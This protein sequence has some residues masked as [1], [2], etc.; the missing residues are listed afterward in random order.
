[1]RH[2]DGSRAVLEYCAALFMLGA[3]GALSAQE[4]AAHRGALQ[5]MFG[6]AGQL[7]VGTLLHRFSESLPP[8]RAREGGRLLHALRVCFPDQIQQWYFGALSALRF[9]DEIKQLMLADLVAG[10]TEAK[11]ANVLRQ[12]ASV[13]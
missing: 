11:L 13:K 8:S 3:D 6:A 12:I 5:Q 4:C 7:I 2:R 9:R 10:D 1:M